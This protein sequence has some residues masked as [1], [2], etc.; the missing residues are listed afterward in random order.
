MAMCAAPTWPTQDFLTGPIPSVGSIISSPP[1]RLADQ[2]VIRALEVASDNVAPFLRLQWLKGR[3]QYEQI[4]S[5]RSHS[6]VWVF[7]DRVGMDQG[8]AGKPH[9]GGMYT[10]AWFVW[11]R[12]ASGPPTQSWIS[13]RL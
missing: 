9:D 2:F 5:R 13:H 10:Y 6:R 3:A 8:A 7:I 1:Y 12:T 11:D 4:L